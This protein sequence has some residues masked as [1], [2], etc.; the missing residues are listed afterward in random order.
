MIT[1]RKVTSLFNKLQKCEQTDVTTP[2]GQVCARLENK[3]WFLFLRV[4]EDPGVL[5]MSGNALA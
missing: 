5:E 3:H 2:K 1:H 4:L